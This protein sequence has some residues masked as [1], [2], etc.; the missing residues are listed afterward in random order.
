MDIFKLEVEVATTRPGDYV[1]VVD[2]AF[3]TGKWIQNIA[4]SQVISLKFGEFDQDT[5]EISEPFPN[6]F[7]HDEGEGWEVGDE[8]Q[9]DG[10]F[11]AFAGISTFE[12]PKLLPWYLTGLEVELT[13]T[14]SSESEAIEYAAEWIPRCF[15]I[16]IGYSEPMSIESVSVQK[17]NGKFTRQPKTT[18]ELPFCEM[19]LIDHDGTS[20]FC[21]ECG[22]KL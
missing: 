3:L 7:S 15:Y 2:K 20:K 10:D 4:M 8:V 1:T 18:D 9:N 21:S 13:V 14:A 6:K 19:C 11:A 16:E 12:F 17:V 5:N 22:H